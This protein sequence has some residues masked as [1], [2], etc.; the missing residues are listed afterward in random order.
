M[1]EKNALDLMLVDSF[2]RFSKNKKEERKGKG[3]RKTKNNFKIIA[4]RN[5]ILAD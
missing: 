1:F 3:M 5:L 4:V 2:Q